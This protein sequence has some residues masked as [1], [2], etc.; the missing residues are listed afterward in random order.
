MP[1]LDR[2]IINLGNKEQSDEPFIPSIPYIFNDSKEEKV[3]ETRYFH[4]DPNP[5]GISY[6]LYQN[7]NDTIARHGIWYTYYQVYNR[8]SVD[9]VV[10]RLEKYNYGILQ[11]SQTYLTNHL[12]EDALIRLAYYDEYG[13]PE[14]IIVLTNG[15]DLYKDNDWSVR[16]RIMKY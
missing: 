2:H 13:Y 8:E 4:R 15:A 3:V 11:V 5:S 9:R 12:V 16:D 6:G 7:I 14:K 10:T 1:L